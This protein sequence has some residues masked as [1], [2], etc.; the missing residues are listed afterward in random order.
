MFIAMKPVHW[1]S[2]GYLRPAGHRATSGYPRDYG[3]GHEEWNAAPAMRFIDANGRAH[4]AFHTEPV[5]GA[6]AHRGDIMLFLYASH[7]GEQTLVGIA[8]R[9]ID[10]TDEAAE[11]VRLARKLGLDDLWKD[12]WTVPLVR[13]RFKDDQNR[14]RQH[15]RSNVGYMPRWICPESHFFWLEK[16]LPLNARALTGN[17][18]FLTM[19]T[20]HTEIDPVLAQRLLDLVQPRDRTSPWRAMVADLSDEANDAVA[21]DLVQLG[22]MRVSA[23]TRKA[24]IEARLGQGKF[25]AGVLANWHDAC[26]VTGCSIAV[27]LRASHIKPWRT[28]SNDER[29]NSAN[30]LP[31]VA[32]LDALFDRY[33]ITFD[34]ND[35]HL[36][37]A[38]TLTTH[39]R[40]ALPLGGGGLL[41]KP[42]G[43]E[44][45]FLVLHNREFAKRHP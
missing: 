21:D 12:V 31:L 9:V 35:G 18:K 25:R 36:I 32:T 30:G 10:L 37:T 16:P 26:A 45:R 2:E 19:F 27:A 28:S 42:T 43:G 5:A 24:L 22:A 15:W 17:E 11:R 29:L 13:Q 44:R 4:R 39:D 6:A 41:R 8:G 3:F 38:P 23:T 20:R 14:L 1:N 40:K 33:L 34:P 7:H